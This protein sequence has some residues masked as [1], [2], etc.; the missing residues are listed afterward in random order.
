MKKILLLVFIVLMVMCLTPGCLPNRDDLNNENQVY[1]TE[2]EDNKNERV[3]ETGVYVG[4]VDNNFIEVKVKDKHISFILTDETK[5]T[6]GEFTENEEI[7]F[8]YYKNQNGQY[9]LVGIAKKDPP[10]EVSKLVE[11]IY[12]G[13]LDN[14]SIEVEIDGSPKVFVNYEMDKVLKGIEEGDK[15]EIKYTENEH[16]QLSLESLRKAD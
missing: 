7:D 4:Q 5:E 10:K 6:I 14:F 13:Q 12:T 3:S 16:G 2:N 15:V 9:V 11:G 1:D 8:V